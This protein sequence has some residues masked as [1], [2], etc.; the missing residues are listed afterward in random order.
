VG[1]I[2]DRVVLGDEGDDVLALGFVVSELLERARHRLVDE[3]HRPAA[4]E[5]LGLDEG[6]LGLDARRVAVH[7]QADRARR[8]EDARLRVPVAVDLPE[9]D[10]LVPR[11]LRRR[12]QGLRHELGVD[13]VDG[14]A[15]LAHHAE[16]RVGVGLV[17]G[18]RPRHL[19]DLGAGAVGPARHDRGDR[20][21]PRTSLIGVVRQ[22]PR[23]QEGAEVRVPEAE[24]TERP[25]VLPDLVC[26]VVRLTDHDL[27]GGEHDLHGVLEA[28]DV[29]VALVVQERHQVEAREVTG[30]VVEVHVLAARVGGV[31]PP[32]RRAG[33]P[34]VDRR[35]VLH[36]GVGALP[37][38]ER[39]V[40]HQ[41][42]RTRGLER[43]PGGDGLQLP[44][45]VIQYGL[46]ELVG[47]AD[48][49]V[50][51][52]VLDRIAVLAVQ[53]H[54]EAGI[55]ERAGLA[56][57]D[58]LA[59]DEVAD[60]WV[61]DVEDHHLGRATRLAARLDRAGRG[62]R[63]AHEADG[64]RGGSAAREPLLGRP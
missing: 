7:H 43:L 48:R 51:V 62:V 58:S 23:H 44:V 59:P 27:L 41:V 5:L 6:E 15:V 29:E 25:R 18:E 16:H 40:P 47:H 1:R 39:D 30:A 9:R 24:L 61:I 10:R 33:V 46:H 38:R 26:R 19:R 57:L 3:L 52:L 36:P 35:V 42:A 14:R 13:V 34:L 20:P 4:H 56:L 31:D 54:V 21:R 49:V 8:R 2:G 45:T 22:T 12:E 53:I 17:A 32:A 60:V 11:L 55:S 63:A 28:D 64:S 37:C 50:G